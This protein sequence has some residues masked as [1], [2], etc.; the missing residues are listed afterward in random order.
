V[1]TNGYIIPG[2]K[3]KNSATIIIQLTKTKWVGFFIPTYTELLK[4]KPKSIASELKEETVKQI[5]K[6]IPKNA[7]KITVNLLSNKGPTSQYKE[8]IIKTIIEITKSNLIGLTFVRGDRIPNFRGNPYK[9]WLVIKRKNALSESDNAQNN[10]PTCLFI[11]GNPKYWIKDT[12]N[13]FYKQILS[14]CHNAGYK[15]LTS[16]SNVHSSKLPEADVAIGFS[17]GTRYLKLPLNKWKHKIGIGAGN[18]M[19]N[20]VYI[21]N[22]PDDK[23]MFGDMSS[24]SLKAHWT[25]TKEQAN[26]LAFLLNK[27]NKK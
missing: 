18:D 22:N 12:S 8:G 14:I 15:V 10:Q 25:L 27:F 21:V 13:K 17:R 11:K 24:S 20:D 1:K 2:T 26:K 23:T 9:S 6:K 16:E 19:P 7:I 4:T 5:T 3:N